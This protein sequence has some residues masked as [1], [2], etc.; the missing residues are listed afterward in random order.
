ML[1]TVYIRSYP[2][3]HNTLF[4]RSLGFLAQGRREKNILMTLVLF[5]VSL[6]SCLAPKAALNASITLVVQ[7]T[8]PLKMTRLNFFFGGG[9]EMKRQKVL[10]SNLRARCRRGPARGQI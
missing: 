6:L 5:R 9:G 10:L 8:C 4:G 3:L 2:A 7:A 1:N